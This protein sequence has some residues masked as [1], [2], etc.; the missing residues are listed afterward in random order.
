MDPYNKI[1]RQS[2]QLLQP[3]VSVVMRAVRNPNLSS[4]QIGFIGSTIYCS[5]LGSLL[6]AKMTNSNCTKYLITQRWE[7]NPIYISCLMVALVGDF[8]WIYMRRFRQSRFP[9]FTIS[10]TFYKLKMSYIPDMSCAIWPYQIVETITQ[11]ATCFIAEARDAVDLNF[12]WP[13]NLIPRVLSLPREGPRMVAAGHVSMH[14]MKEKRSSLPTGSPYGLFR[15]FLSSSLGT[16]E[17]EES[18]Q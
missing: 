15:D 13:V 12:A 17:R 7:S 11:F 6:L 10:Q 2:K 14:A 9:S 8:D 4:E 3:A 5:G 16:G 1:A 18:L